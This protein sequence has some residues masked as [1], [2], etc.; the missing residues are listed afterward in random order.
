M[1]QTKFS[2][3]EYQADFLNNFKSYGFLSFQSVGVY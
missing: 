2:I 1:L 3:K